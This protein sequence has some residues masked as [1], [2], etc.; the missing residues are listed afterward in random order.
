M[1]PNSNYEF[2][3]QLQTNHSDT[4]AATSDASSE[5][6]VYQSDTTHDKNHSRTLTSSDI[7]SKLC[8][9]RRKKVLRKRRSKSNNAPNSDINNVKSCEPVHQVK[10]QVAIPAHVTAEVGNANNC[11]GGND[12]VYS[13]PLDPVAINIADVKIKEEPTEFFD[14]NG[15]TEPDYQTNLD[16]VNVKVDGNAAIKDDVD[17][18]GDMVVRG[19][20]SPTVTGRNMSELLNNED[21]VKSKDMSV[22]VISDT[23]SENLLLKQ[24]PEAEYSEPSQ[25]GE[26]NF[27]NFFLLL[28][29]IG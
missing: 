20:L 21:L 15:T 12:H 25:Q 14:V 4:S 28:L 24:E 29:N 22:V 1:D 6:S 8:T 27:L 11:P 26:F 10:D 18:N 9:I 7:E 5:C 17:S 3:L 16:D 23:S 13:G 19:K 2:K